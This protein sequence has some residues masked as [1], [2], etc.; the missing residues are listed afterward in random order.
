MFVGSLPQGS[1]PEELRRL[2]E[3]YGVVTECDIMNRCGFIHFETQEMADNA[4]AALHNSTFKNAVITVERGRLKERKANGG[5]AGG[6]GGMRQNMQGGNR[7]GNRQ[8]RNGMNGGGPRMNMM[9]N[10]MQGNKQMNGGGGGGGDGGRPMRNN[11]RGMQRNQPYPRD[12]PKG[13]MRNMG[14]RMDRFDNMDNRGGKPPCLISF[15]NIVYIF[16]LF[17]SFRYGTQ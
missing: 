16:L 7:Q 1:K 2:F 11:N 14:Q 4:I 13:G 8:G 15:P 17:Y 12:G 6:N 9:G 10:R 5:N 3:K